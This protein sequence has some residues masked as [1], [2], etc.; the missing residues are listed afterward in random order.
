MNKIIALIALLLVLSMGSYARADIIGGLN[1]TS[2]ADSLIS[3][4]GTFYTTGWS[5]ASEETVAAL[6]TDHD[7]GTC[8]FSPSPGAY[9]QLGF[10]QPIVNGPGNDLAL[11]ELGTEDTFKLSLTLAGTTNEYLSAY[12]GFSVIAGDFEYNLNVA[13]INLDD[14]GLPVGALVDQIVVGLDLQSI[15][16]Q[17]PS[18][19][20]AGALDPVPV[21]GAV[22]LLG[23]GLLA[24]VIRGR[25]KS[26]KN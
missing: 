22:W 2:F 15:Y 21:P 11:F 19:S 23:S 16:G 10:S 17:R 1:I 12:T 14:F 20:L 9:V 7:P 26:K 13:Q 25:W 6:L 8:V 18:L 24:L 3:L 5:P 4:N